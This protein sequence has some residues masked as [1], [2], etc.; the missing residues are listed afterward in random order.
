MCSTPLCQASSPNDTATKANIKKDFAEHPAPVPEEEGRSRKV[1]CHL[2]A[3]VEVH[4]VKVGE[5]QDGPQ[6]DK[7]DGAGEGAQ[8]GGDKQRHRAA[9]HDSHAVARAHSLCVECG[10]R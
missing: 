9:Q 2:E 7:Q 5:E 10:K 6:G 3:Q 8:E 4:D 1:H